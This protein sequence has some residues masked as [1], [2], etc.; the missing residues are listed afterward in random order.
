MNFLPSISLSMEIIFKSINSGIHAI[1]ICLFVYNVAFSDKINDYRSGH[2]N[3]DDSRETVPHLNSMLIITDDSRSNHKKTW[4]KIMND[5]IATFPFFNDVKGTIKKEM[6]NI[7][8]RK[9][10]ELNINSYIKRDIGS[11]LKKRIYAALRKKE[12]DIIINLVIKTNQLE[13]R[14]FNQKGAKIAFYK[15]KRDPQISGS[16][17]NDKITKDQRD[18]LIRAELNDLFTEF[19]DRYFYKTVKLTRSNDLIGDIYLNDKF[20]KKWKGTTPIIVDNIPRYE[21]VTVHILT[22][23]S[24]SNNIIIKGEIFS[25]KEAN[26]KKNQ[27]KDIGN[28]VPSPVFKLKGS[29]VKFNLFNY[30]KI[31]TVSDAVNLRLYDINLFGLK[32]VL[33]QEY[34]TDNFLVSSKLLGSHL[35]SIKVN[36]SRRTFPRFITLID[37]LEYKIKHGDIHTVGQEVNNRSKTIGRSL[38]TLMPGLGHIYVDRS[39]FQ[40]LFLTGL[41]CFL[42]YKSVDEYNNFISLRKNYDNWQKKYNDLD[43]TDPTDT[44]SY[45]K[46]LAMDYHNSAETSRKMYYIY[47]SGLIITNVASTLHMEL[48]MNWDL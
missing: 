22:T 21:D 41:Y 12:L 43:N 30:K 25:L 29:L 47:F 33:D 32:N 18:Q 19:M 26:Q 31:S 6:A 9:G 45:Y 39:K 35:Y 5:R 15:R 37:S 42:I 36:N 38:S 28:D 27:K 13:I 1:I 10:W 14:F 11:K 16:I 8:S 24:V 48:R 3:V 46:S 2:I 7:L 44:Y 23:D 17:N 40:Y 4:E 34:G 20:K